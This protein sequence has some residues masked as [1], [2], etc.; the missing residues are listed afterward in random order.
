MIRKSC[1]GLAEMRKSSLKAPKG[2]DISDLCLPYRVALQACC[3][4]YVQKNYCTMFKKTIVLCSL[5]T[6]RRDHMILYGQVDG[7]LMQ[8]AKVLGLPVRF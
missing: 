6:F 8:A 3:Y 1:L 2:I 4:S 5:K 7:C